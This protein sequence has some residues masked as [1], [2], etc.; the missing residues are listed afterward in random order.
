MAARRSARPT[1]CLSEDEA[2]SRLHPLAGPLL[3]TALGMARRTHGN[4]RRADGAP[5]LE[6]H[7]FPVAV[8]VAEY[9]RNRLPAERLLNA[10]IVALLH[11]ALEDA[12]Q[13]D[14]PVTRREIE[15]HFGKPTAREIQALTK[16]PKDPRLDPD[17]RGRMTRY[18]SGLE[19]ASY[20]ARVVKVFDR[21]NN[22]EC[23]HKREREK[24][25]EYIDETRE[26]YLPLAEAVD[27]QLAVRM[28][29][30]VERLEIGSG[31]NEVGEPALD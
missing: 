2:R 24:I 21:V 15:R 18:V 17:G 10:V 8:A 27:A 11:D 29:A 31:Q 5:Y 28:R 13:S 14:D 9:L 3:T 12:D 19:R 26:H 22:L 25:R 7:I 30:L 16:P 6:E 20:E 1:P 4:Q 23:L